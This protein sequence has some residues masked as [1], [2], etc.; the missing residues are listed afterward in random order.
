VNRLLR[1]FVSLMEALKRH[2]G[3]SEQAV[4]VRH[5]T[6]AEGG[7]AI[8]GNVTQDQRRAADPAAPSAIAEEKMISDA[9]H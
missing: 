9:D 8:V 1:T 3:G 4:T 2:R 7:Q 5:V 6:V